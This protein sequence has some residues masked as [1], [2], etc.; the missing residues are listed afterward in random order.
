MGKTI[1]LANETYLVNDI[2]STNE[3]RVGTWTNGKPVYRKTYT[4]TISLDSSGYYII[5]DSSLKNID[6]L[7]RLDCHLKDNYTF[8]PIPN[9]DDRLSTIYINSQWGYIGLIVKNRNYD[10]NFNNK[11]CN[12]IVEYTKTTD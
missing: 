10:S 5:N 12:I 8:V 3:V 2:Y 6:T 9:I 4:G 1:K 11:E 7:L